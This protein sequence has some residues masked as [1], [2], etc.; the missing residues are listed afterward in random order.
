VEPLENMVWLSVFWPRMLYLVSSV[1]RR[2]S[3]VRLKLI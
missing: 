2:I 1:P 3:K